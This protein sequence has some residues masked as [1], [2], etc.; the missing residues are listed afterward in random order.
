[1]VEHIGYPDDDFTTTKLVSPYLVKHNLIE[2]LK[3]SAF[4]VVEESNEDVGCTKNRY[5]N[6]NMESCKEYD[7]EK[8]KLS[9][10]SGD[11]SEIH[12]KYYG[13][14]IRLLLDQ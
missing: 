12:S 3:E 13:R 14:N 7:F 1:M 6:R 4:C 5:G 8:I 9:E 10:L 2:A 11:V